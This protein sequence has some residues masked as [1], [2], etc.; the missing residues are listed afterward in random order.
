MPEKFTGA[1]AMLT[2]LGTE[3]G[4]FDPDYVG[5]MPGTRW[6][7]VPGANF[8]DEDPSRGRDFF[9]IDIEVDVPSG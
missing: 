9:T 3:S 8:G 4:L 1:Q 5:L 7:P 2:R 6:L